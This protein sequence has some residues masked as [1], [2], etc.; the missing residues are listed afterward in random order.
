MRARSSHIRYRWLVIRLCLSGLGIAAVVFSYQKPLELHWSTNSSSLK[1]LRLNEGVVSLLTISGA[2]SF[3]LKEGERLGV[4]TIRSGE[5]LGLHWSTWNQVK[6]GQ[7]GTFGQW[8]EF[9]F[10]FWWLLVPWLSFVAWSLWKRTGSPPDSG[11]CA[12][13]GYDLRATP[14]RCPEC[15]TIPAATTDAPARSPAGRSG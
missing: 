13:C 3:T 8:Q 5:F 11:L 14:D 15:G 4:K 12:V 10:S 2:T 1:E 7:A 6:I 9:W